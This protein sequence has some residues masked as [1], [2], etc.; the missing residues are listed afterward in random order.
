MQ[1]VTPQDLATQSESIK[2]PFYK[3]FL[4]KGDTIYDI[5]AFKGVL[6]VVFAQQG[7]N[8]IAIEG[9]ETNYDDLVANTADYPNIKPVLM[10]LHEKNEGHSLCRDR[11][12]WIWR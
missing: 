3:T 2:T 6:S 10:A 12:I 1:N 5:G 11:P 4:N 8:V 9:S 7:F